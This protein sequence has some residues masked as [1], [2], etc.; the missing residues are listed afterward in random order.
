[1]NAEFSLQKLSLSK[2]IRNTTT[3]SLSLKSLVIVNGYTLV[4]E[5][6]S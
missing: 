3:F 5:G 6:V 4:S 1:M 2:Y